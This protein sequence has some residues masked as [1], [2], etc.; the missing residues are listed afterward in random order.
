MGKRKPFRWAKPRACIIAKR[1]NFH[2][3]QQVM[4]SIE[5]WSHRGAEQPSREFTCAAAKARTNDA[6]LSIPGKPATLHLNFLRSSQSFRPPVPAVSHQA[7]ATIGFWQWRNGSPRPKPAEFQYQSLRCVR[8]NFHETH[9]NV[10]LQHGHQ[11]RSIYCPQ[12]V[13]SHGRLPQSFT[14][15]YID[16][17]IAVVRH[18]N[19]Y[20]PTVFASIVILD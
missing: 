4:A 3:K 5:H 7:F 17:D 19:T 16:P 12:M 9:G 15:A 13:I 2:P 14:V 1:Y 11:A 6:A 20:P 10:L 8:V 18:I